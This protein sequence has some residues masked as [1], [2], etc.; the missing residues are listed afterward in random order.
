[1]GAVVPYEELLDDINEGLQAFAREEFDFPVEEELP[2]LALF[3]HLTFAREEIP[4]VRV[5]LDR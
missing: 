1:M 4:A 5:A 3:D 2:P